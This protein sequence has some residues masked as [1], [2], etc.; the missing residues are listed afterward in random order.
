MHDIATATTSDHPLDDN[1][2][3]RTDT[4][5]SGRG[6]SG[7]ARGS[8][9]GIPKPPTEPPPPATPDLDIREISASLDRASVSVTQQLCAHVIIVALSVL[10]ITVFSDVFD[11]GPTILDHLLHFGQYY[12]YVAVCVG[13]SSV[14]LYVLDVFSWEGTCSIILKR[15]FGTLLIVA[16]IVLGITGVREYPYAPLSFFICLLPLAALTI[17]VMLL[18]QYPPETAAR[19]LGAPFVLAAMVTVAIWLSW[20][21]GAWGLHAGQLDNY[22]FANRAHF[23]SLAQ[24]NTSDFEAYGIYTTPD[25]AVTCTAAFL[26]W[27]SPLIV[28]IVSLFIGLFLLVLSR[29]IRKPTSYKTT[30]YIRSLATLILICLFG[31]YSA[32]T[33]GG[34]NLEL[35]KVALAIFAVLMVGIVVVWGGTIGWGNSGKRLS[36]LQQALNDIG[37]TPKKGFQAFSLVVISPLFVVGLTLSWISQRLRVMGFNHGRCAPIDEEHRHY[38]FTAPFEKALREMRFWD[39][40]TVLKFSYYLCVFFWVFSYF[41]QLVYIFFNWL[42]TVLRPLSFGIVVVIFVFIGLIMFLIPV[43]PGPAV[44][45]TAGVLVV[46]LGKSTIAGGAAYDAC[47]ATSAADAIDD[48]GVWAFWVSCAI[49]SAIS[50]AL[51]LI[52]HVLQQ[53]LIGEMLSHRVGIR[54]M[55]QINTPQMKAVKHILLQPG[56]TLA[57]VSILCGGPDWPTS[58]LCGI[59]RLNCCQMLI[60][61]APIIFFTTPGTLL[62]AFLTEPAYSD[63]NLDTLC[64]IL[65]FLIQLLLV[66]AFMYYMNQVLH[67]QKQL[68]ATHPDYKDDSEVLVEDK[69]AA[70]FDAFCAEH[71]GFHLAPCGLRFLLLIGVFASVL[72]TYALT[73]GASSLFQKFLITDCLDHLG[74]PPEDYVIRVLGM[75]KLGLVAICMMLFGGICLK[76]FDMWVQRRWSEQ[77]GGRL[78]RMDDSATPATEMMEPSE[79]APPPASPPPPA[80]PSPHYAHAPQPVAAP[81]VSAPTFRQQQPP[82][83]HQQRRVGESI[84]GGGEILVGYLSGEL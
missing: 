81:A 73:F 82:P 83:P 23:A 5:G 66:L 67:T 11:V 29:A 72:S 36:D 71:C 59:L 33:V 39:W 62:G 32:T 65:V 74:Y 53:K 16:V 22:W 75:K 56:L 34:A 19:A 24:C 25:G 78:H 76:A 57:K 13:L 69:R 3:I 20:L 9:A 40:A 44:Y 50:F 35:A 77:A 18:A 79:A 7:A 12:E 54:A 63:I 17:R 46:P 37:D 51:K 80:P 4:R 38:T 64:L 68:L 14:V 15:L 58:V 2:S 70:D 42:V 27:A 6:A 31:M 45:L 10:I 47:N 8:S 41:P 30:L 43:V 48:S 55:C 28:S 61:L 52:A 49:A 60:G 1:V 84:L 26:L 21:Y